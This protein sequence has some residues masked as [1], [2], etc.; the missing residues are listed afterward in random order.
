M[1]RIPNILLGAALSAVGIWMA[2]TAVAQRS[3]QAAVNSAIEIYS[4]RD[5]RPSE[6]LTTAL[7]EAVEAAPRCAEAHFRLGRVLQR[8]GRDDD[9]ARH[10]RSAVALN[11]FRGA[12]HYWLG[13]LETRRGRHV[14]ATSR[15]R[16]TVT[17]SANQ[18]DHLFRVGYYFYHRWKITGNFLQLEEALGCFREAA[19]LDLSFLFKAF[20]ILREFALHYDT[21]QLLIPD[22]EEAHIEAGRY[23]GYNTGLWLFSLNEFEKAREKGAVDHHIRFPLMYGTALLHNGRHKDAR[24]QILRGLDDIGAP[25]KE[26]LGLMVHFRAA[27][28][29]ELGAEV[30][31]ELA[32]LYPN[33]PAPL[34]NL[35]DF[36]VQMFHRNYKREAAALQEEKKKKIAEARPEEREWIR[37]NYEKKK[38]EV[39]NRG[40][41]GL[42]AFYLSALTKMN[43]LAFFQRLGEIENMLGNAV[44]TE[45]W[46]R[47]ALDCDRDQIS[48]WRNTISFLMK[49][50]RYDDAL[51]HIKEALER[52]PG[53]ERLRRMREV[54]LDYKIRHKNGS[55]GD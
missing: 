9:A 26:I 40:L 36:K 1:R 41:D 6:E 50:K 29:K 13:R 49:I 48:S 54:A 18:V 14:A 32:A 43:H 19:A 55:A 21:L 31:Q 7:R 2:V 51:Q 52:F 28:A 35:G 24:E 45:H 16:L 47:K 11:P 39:W 27:R 42:R 23:F 12:I 20:A 17:L 53:D 22:T 3:R 34:I 44:Q 38:K 15:M 37:R 46:L 5:G 33:N 4:A 10:L 8:Q 25:E 30:W